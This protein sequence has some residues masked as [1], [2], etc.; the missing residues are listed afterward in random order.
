MLANASYRIVPRSDRRPELLSSIAAEFKRV[1]TLALTVEQAR[2]LWAL[3]SGT[4]V[5]LLEWLVEEGLLARRH[6]GRYV[7]RLRAPELASIP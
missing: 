3:E 5:Q 4:C 2:R 6:D 7:V 1:P